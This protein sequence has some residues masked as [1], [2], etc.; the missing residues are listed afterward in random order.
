MDKVELTQGQADALI[1]IRKMFLDKSPLIIN[2]PSNI[3][4]EL[5]SQGNPEDRFYLNVSQKAIEFGRYSSV[6]R[7]F[8]VPLIRACINEDSIHENPDGEVIKGC[9]IHIYKEGNRDNYAYPLSKYG[10]SSIEMTKFLSDFL[11]LCAIEKIDI[12]EQTLIKD[13]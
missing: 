3:Q 1:N 6:T 8:S 2:R 11:K 13:E 9:H 7:F 4:R 5:Q 10:F 12:I